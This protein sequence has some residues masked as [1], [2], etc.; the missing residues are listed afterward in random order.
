M[1]NTYPLQLLQAINDWQCGGDAKQNIRRGRALKKACESLPERYRTCA[2]CCF[3]QVALPKGGV[4]SLIGENCLPEK[5]SSWTIDI[6]VAKEFKGGVPPKGQGYQGVILCMHPQQA[7]VIVNLK[8]LY[9]DPAFVEELERNKDRIKGYYKGTGLYGNKQSEVVL[10]V[11]SL[12][13]QDI[14]SLGDH[15]SAFERLVAVAENLLYGGAATPNERKTLMLDVEPLRSQ[16]GPMWLAPDA[17]QRV[18]ERMKPHSE[19]LREV[20]R[21]QKPEKQ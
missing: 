17:T 21:H 9:Q 13:P 11:A 18:V 2:L 16:A 15:S 5:I 8:E 7:S 6:T 14:Y 4:W 20:K 12:S 10:E 1:P 3:R 19:R